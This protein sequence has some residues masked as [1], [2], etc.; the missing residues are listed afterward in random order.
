MWCRCCASTASAVPSKTVQGMRLMG[1]GGQEVD[2]RGEAGAVG[3]RPT[4]AGRGGGAWIAGGDLNVQ[5]VGTTIV[6]MTDKQ[7]LHKHLEFIQNVIARLANNSFLMKGW[8]VTVSGAFFGFAIQQHE[9]ALALIGLLPA[10][11]LWALDAYF[12]K[13][14]RQ[15][16]RLFDSVRTHPESHEPF[17]M[18]PEPYHAHVKSWSRTFFSLTLWPFYGGIVLVGVLTALLRSQLFQDLIDCLSKR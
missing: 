1:R 13:K 2:Q 3:Q 14:E 11:S 17:D 12:V 16:R 18:N 5:H 8:A 6:L 10:I 4:G 15:F 9:A 7:D